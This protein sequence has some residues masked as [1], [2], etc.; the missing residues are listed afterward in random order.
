[1]DV[2]DPRAKK[3]SY[4]LH[5]LQEAIRRCDAAHWHQPE[6]AFTAAAE[7]VSW[8]VAL[9]VVLEQSSDDGRDPQAYK[10]VRSQ[11]PEGQTVIGM[12]FVRNHVHHADELLDFVVLSAIVGSPTYGMR[13]GWIWKPLSELEPLLDSKF[14][15]GKGLYEACLGGKDVLHTLLDAR[16]WFTSLSPPLPTLPPDLTGISRAAFELPD[17]WPPI[18]GD[19]RV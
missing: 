15:S 14:K 18:Q 19:R 1:M 11:G 12:K 3:L 9:D 6:D 8:V 10:Q 5:G 13:A 17:R 2:D 16:L 4:S 7:G